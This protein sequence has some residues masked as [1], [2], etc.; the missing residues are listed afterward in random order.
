MTVVIN[1][2]RPDSRDASA[3]IEELD[4]VLDPLYPSESRHGFSIDK[5]IQDNVAF[6]V[7]RE[8]GKPA[9]CGGV[10]LFG[11][12]YGEVKRMYV[13]PEFRGA[14]LG[15]KMLRHLE[16]Y[17]RKKGVPLLRLET[18]IYQSEAIGMYER[19]GFERVGPFGEYKEDPNSIFFEKRT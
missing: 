10:K 12:E 17:A 9:G 4:D 13:R 1:A 5:L 16:D 6:F 7:V 19:Y 8:D 2:E 18:G 14:G 11:T 15:R 3:L